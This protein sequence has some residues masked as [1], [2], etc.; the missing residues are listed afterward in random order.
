MLHRFDAMLNGVSFAGLD[1]A[2]ILT[3]INEQAP[4]EDIETASRAIHPGTRL[5]F[6]R[7]RNLSVRL[8]FVVREYD[9]ARRATLMDKIAD[10]A[11][12]DGWL[13]LS[14]RPDQRL[15]VHADTLP[16]MG[17]SLRWTDDIIIAMTAYERPYFE[18]RWP[19]VSVISEQ[20]S[21][22]PLGTVPEAYVEVDVTNKG[23]GDLTTLTATCA[24]TRIKLEGLSVPPGEHIRI[25]YTDKDVLTITAAGVS[26]L[27]NRTADSHDDLIAYT[28]QSNIITVEADQ[29]VTAEFSARGRWR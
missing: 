4:K 25:A 19:V 27:A 23:A 13:V 10:W 28:R 8:T 7:R 12:D 24:T 29:P 9:P 20:G 17:S 3:D 22:C 16:A 18:A 6:R 1:P 2:I 21:I 26:A 14:T 5:T 11:V 15:Y